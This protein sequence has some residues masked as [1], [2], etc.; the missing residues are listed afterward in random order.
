MQEN[1]CNVNPE[2]RKAVRHNQPEASP[3]IK[4]GYLDFQI[5]IPRTVEID[6]FEP[7]T[8]CLQSRCSS[9]L[10]YTP[11]FSFLLTDNFVIPRIVGHL[12]K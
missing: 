12:P 6:G 8:L 1:L 3:D 11:V 5:T 7:T 2:G 9:Q 10:S 4:N